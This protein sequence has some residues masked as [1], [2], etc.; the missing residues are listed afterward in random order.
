MNTVRTTLL[1]LA[2]AGEILVGCSSAPISVAPSSTPLLPQARGGTLVGPRLSDAASARRPVDASPPCPVHLVDVRDTRV[3]PDALGMMGLRAVRTA[4]SAAWLQA[5]L[6]TLKQ[7][8]R[9]RY[10]DDAKDATFDLRIEL[11]KAYV[12][13]MNTQKTANVVLR[14]SYSRDGKPL[15]AQIARGRDTGANWVNG[16]DEAQGAL[17]RALAAAVV[18]ID[19]DIVTRCR[20]LTAGN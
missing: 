17:D 13:T 11:V 12:M 6:A 19:S 16:D 9:L 18:E 7:D 14:A 15:D 5:G 1:S 8:G 20:A 2:I 4:D 10:A 3:D